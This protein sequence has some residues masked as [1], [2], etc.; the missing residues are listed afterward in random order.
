MNDLYPAIAVA[1]EVLVSGGWIQPVRS[2]VAEGILSFRRGA[3]LSLLCR[4]RRPAR[5]LW[6]IYRASVKL[7]SELL[8]Y[9]VMSS[10]SSHLRPFN[11][12][13]VQPVDRC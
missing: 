9:M 6:V 3:A 12:I 5:R 11:R 2:E 10:E 13:Q 4:T 8:L 1:C 7:A